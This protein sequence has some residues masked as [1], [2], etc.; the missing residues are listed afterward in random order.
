MARWEP[1]KSDPGARFDAEITIDVASLAPL[2]TWGTRPDMVEP[3]TGRVPDP[4]GAASE[5]D[6]HAMERALAYMGLT[7]GMAIENMPIDRSSSVP[8]PT[9]GSKTCAL[10]PGR[11]GHHVAP[12]ARDG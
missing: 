10:P 7:P 6:A 2:V 3:I 8:A 12:G 11:E 1:L 5:G 4:K 9:R